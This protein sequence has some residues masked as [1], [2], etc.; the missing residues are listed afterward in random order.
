MSDQILTQHQQMLIVDSVCHETRLAASAIAD[1]L[2][3]YISMLRPA[4]SIDGNKWCALYG[5]NLQDGVA[6][7]GDS[8]SEALQ[9]FNAAMYRKLENSSE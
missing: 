2:A 5:E 8:P 9:D 1:G 3:S 4:L 7:F 6:G